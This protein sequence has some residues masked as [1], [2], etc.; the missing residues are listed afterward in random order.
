MLRGKKLQYVRIYNGIS[1]KEIAKR[2]GVEPPYIS[3]LEN[4]KQ[5]IPEHIYDKWVKAL[6]S[7]SVENTS[8]VDEVILEKAIE[9]PKVKQEI[10]SK[11]K[12]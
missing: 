6:Y 4:E 11:K 8:N 9:Q 12:D 10:K 3:M 1:Q 2:I 7:G 5:D